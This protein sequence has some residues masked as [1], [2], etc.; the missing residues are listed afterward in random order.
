MH[1]FSPS[2]VYRI[3]LTSTMG[4]SVGQ[5]KEFLLELHSFRGIVDVVVVFL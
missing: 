4:P 3:F 2:F 5:H 1:L